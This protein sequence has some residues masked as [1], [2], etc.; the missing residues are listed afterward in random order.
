MIHS[1]ATLVLYF[2]D[3]WVLRKQVIGNSPHLV[4]CEMLYEEMMCTDDVYS[5][6]IQMLSAAAG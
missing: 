5:L 2:N 1:T 3:E 6:L 4:D